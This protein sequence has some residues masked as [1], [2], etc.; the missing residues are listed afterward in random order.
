VSTLNIA[1]KSLTSA[2]Y[3][4]D[5][6]KIP[7]IITGDTLDSK[8]ILRGECVN[9]LIK[10][11]KLYPKLETYVLVGNHDLIN[12]KGEDHSLNFLKPYVTVIDT[13]TYVHDIGALMIP[14]MHD[15]IKLS[16][17]IQSYSP[18]RT[19]LILH[20]GVQSANMGHYQQDKTSLPKEIFSDF[21]VISGHY[22]CR[23][24]I[25][26]GRPRKGAVGLFSYIGNPYTLSFGE[27]NDPPKGYQILHED[28][29][30]NP[31]PLNLRKHVIIE[32]NINQL[33]GCIDNVNTDDI[34]WL[35][36]IGPYVELEQLKKKEIGDRLFGHL[37]FKFDKI[38]TDKA[39]LEV[40][41]D[42]L[43]G[44]QIFD[45]LIDSTDEKSDEKAALKN[46]WREVLE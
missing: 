22:H 37:N 40:K 29:I 36:V 18:V 8:A 21:R 43:T 44:E 28:G 31:V 27:A 17:I 26:T 15:A 7:L 1:T 34:I 33:Y 5:S 38:Y 45:S 32:R 46:L 4:A 3:D 16:E 14:Y 12:E 13:P 39:K 30:L 6:L 41:S 42:K 23:Q 35:K 20:Q 11:F 24:D 10:I 19:K 9:E 2:Q 25:K